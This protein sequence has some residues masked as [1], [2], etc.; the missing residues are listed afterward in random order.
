MKN[1]LIGILVVVI[2]S[3]I[4]Y[5][6]WAAI[7]QPTVL[8]E[9]APITETKNTYATSTFSIQ[10]PSSYILNDVYFY[11][12]FEGKPIVGVKF[13]IPESLASGTNLSSFDTGVSVESLPRAKRCTGDIYVFANV[14]TVDLTVGST[15]YSVAT[16][17]VAATGTG[18][19]TDTFLFA[20]HRVRGV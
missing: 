1:T 14:K 8:P 20:P 19:E 5:F 11:D 16:S 17:T 10:Y 18:C 15:T 7:S 13:V 3:I 2:L 12:Q 6:I 9:K 4:G